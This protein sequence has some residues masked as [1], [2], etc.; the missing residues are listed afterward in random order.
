LFLEPLDDRPQPVGPLHMEGRGHVVQEPRVVDDHDRRN[1]GA[2]FK[3]SS[4]DESGAP[5]IGSPPVRAKVFSSRSKSGPHAG[6]A[7]DP[8][9]GSSAP[10]PT[11]RDG[12]PPLREM[13]LGL[14][15]NPLP[16]PEFARDAGGR[17]AVVPRLRAA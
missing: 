16:R 11:R 6:D 2:D 13:V 15:D 9:R 17:G 7:P 4:A 3:A 14:A 5:S 12:P 10:S 8:P 1:G